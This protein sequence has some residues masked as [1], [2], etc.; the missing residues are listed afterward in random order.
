[1]YIVLYNINAIPVYIK[2]KGCAKIKMN[3]AIT[4]VIYACGD[5]KILVFYLFFA[6]YYFMPCIV[7]LLFYIIVNFCIYN[8]TR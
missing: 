4:Y 2:K 8:V 6:S 7:S 5:I 3:T 1:M